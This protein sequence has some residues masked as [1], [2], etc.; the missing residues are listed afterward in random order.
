MKVWQSPVPRSGYSA[1]NAREDLKNI[2]V[3]PL[4]FRSYFPAYT[5]EITTVDGGFFQ[6]RAGIFLR[7]F[8]DADR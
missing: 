5:R 6:T 8:A 4:R 3:D 1:D 7:R 2:I